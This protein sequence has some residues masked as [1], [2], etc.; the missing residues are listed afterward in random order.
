MNNAIKANYYSNNILK[1]M[2][3][4]ENFTG[5]K[6]FHEV[7]PEFDVNFWEAQGQS[8][9]KALRVLN[10]VLNKIIDDLNAGDSFVF[11]RLNERKA[12]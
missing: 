11:D 12:N 8:N 5:T 10:E 4:V 6:L 9:V 3:T 7:L 1:G 2:A